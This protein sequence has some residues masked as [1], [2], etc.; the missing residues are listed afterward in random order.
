MALKIS[1]QAIFSLEL[2]FALENHQ[3]NRSV[4]YS[5]ICRNK[6]FKEISGLMT[7][8]VSVKKV[9]REWYFFSFIRKNVIGGRYIS[10]QIVKQMN[11]I[12]NCLLI[13]MI[14]IKLD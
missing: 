4:C 12:G 2:R 3:Q 13:I 7:L 11:K 6:T 9:T 1:Q 5:T 8:I 14:R 10:M